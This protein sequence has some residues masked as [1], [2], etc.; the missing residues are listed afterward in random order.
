M[1]A[2]SHKR[3]SLTWARSN[4]LVLI[5]ACVIAA[6]LL[7]GRAAARRRDVG[8]VLPVNSQRVARARERIDP[9]SASAASLRR[10]GGIGPRR[11]QDIVAYASANGPV[12]FRCSDDLQRVRGIGPGVARRIAPYLH[13]PSLRPATTRR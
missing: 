2:S 5:V 12:A 6:S 8:R 10:L 4:V 3:F 9:N 7:A 11:A 1:S 13:F